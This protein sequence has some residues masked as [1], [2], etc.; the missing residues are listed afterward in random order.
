V[1]LWRTVGRSV[2]ATLNSD[3]LTDSTGGGPDVWGLEVAVNEDRDRVRLAAWDEHRTWGIDWQ[4]DRAN[5]RE[6]R[7]IL[8]EALD[9]PSPDE[10]APDNPSTSSNSKE[11]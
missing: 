10:T 2:D 11:G 1:S 4:L 6:L 8:T 7:D 3:A 9:G 5:L